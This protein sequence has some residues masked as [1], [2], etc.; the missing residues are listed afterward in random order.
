MAST[1]LCAWDGFNFRVFHLDQTVGFHVPE[2]SFSRAGATWSV[3][4]T[5]A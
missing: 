3:F 4:L 5:L 1:A 2:N